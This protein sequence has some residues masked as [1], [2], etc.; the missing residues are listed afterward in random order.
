M[1]RYADTP[2][3][4]YIYKESNPKSPFAED[5]N[6]HSLYSASSQPMTCHH[7]MYTTAPKHANSFDLRA[8][9]VWHV[10]VEATY[11]I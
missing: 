3:S 4:L 9:H 2:Y 7:T 11:I 5:R 8:N 1:T 6:T 10:P